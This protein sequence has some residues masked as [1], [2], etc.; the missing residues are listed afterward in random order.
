MILDNQL[1]LSAEQDIVGIS[2]GGTVTST[3]V[4]TIGKADFGYKGMFLAVITREEI[5][6][7]GTNGTLTITIEA[8]DDSSFSDSSEIV[9]ATKV[10]TLGA[11]ATPKDTI[12][13][14]ELLRD[15]GGKKFLRVKYKGT[16]YVK[17]S[18]QTT[19]NVDAF[20]AFDYPNK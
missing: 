17:A 19:I 9:L 6:T 1:V 15:N 16:T 8:S 14:K 4:A 5:K 20:M 7:A 3:N 10:V 11:T 18:G 12:L 2:S 13:F